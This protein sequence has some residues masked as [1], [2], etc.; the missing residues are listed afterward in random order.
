MTT[1]IKKLAAVSALVVVLT[2]VAAG[3]ARADDWHGHERDAYR[4]HRAHPH[5]VYTDVYA[6]PVVVTPPPVYTPEP[7]YAAPAAPSLNFV[8][9]L[10]FH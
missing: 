2:I 3:A 5:P 8:I 1:L 7:V 4:W 6:P 9:P 10:H